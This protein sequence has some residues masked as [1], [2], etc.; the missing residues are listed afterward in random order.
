ME[1]GEVETL[2]E[3][4]GAYDIIHD[5]VFVGEPLASPMTEYDYRFKGLREFVEAR[6]PKRIAVNFKHDLGAWPT[7]RA[8]D[9]ISH[10]DYLLLAKELG[11]KYAQQAGLV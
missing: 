5:P 6:D 1:R 3:E 10:T 7:R 2:I 8:N 4:S 9:G 11:D